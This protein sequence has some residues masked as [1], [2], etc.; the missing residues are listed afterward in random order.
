MT[1]RAAV[2][3][4]PIAQSKSPGMHNHWI[5][6]LGID[7]EYVA[8]LAP[9]DGFEAEVRSLMVDGFAGVNVTMPF[10]QEALAIADTSSDIARKIGAANTLIFQN[11]K[12]HADNTDGYGFGQNILSQFPKWNTRGSHIVLGAGGAAAAIVAW[13]LEQGSQNIILVNR[14]LDRA[15]ELA[16]MSEDIKVMGWEQLP[17][18][19]AGNSTLINTTSLGMNGENDIEFDFSTASPDMIVN[20]IVY[21]P[22]ETGLL[23]SAKSQGLN[24]VD[25]L[26]MLLWQGRPGFKAWFGQEAPEIDDELRGIMLK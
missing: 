24:V 25:G 19:L 18:H 3:G 6:K 17:N 5:K 9:L 11:G 26:G 14:N 20:D 10:K 4:N 21:S 15:N 22:L 16:Q 7:G 1:I 23:K 8:K 13:L 2:F 12:I